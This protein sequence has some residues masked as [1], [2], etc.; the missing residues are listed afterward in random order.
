MI[1]PRLHEV[2]YLLPEN[3]PT[4][5]ARE[6][7]C[8]IDNF[9]RRWI[10]NSTQYKFASRDGDEAEPI[11]DDIYHHEFK[12][13]G[14]DTITISRDCYQHAALAWRQGKD[15]LFWFFRQHE[16][17]DEFSFAGF[18]RFSTMREESLFG[19]SQFS[20]T[21]LLWKTMEAYRVA[22]IQETKNA[23]TL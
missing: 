16:R 12:S 10:K 11:C 2:F 23:T 22:T 6:R 20:G 8:A 13:C 5:N 17:P 19:G 3:G 14:T 1:Y 7:G 4:G 15:T 18:I 9:A 21:T